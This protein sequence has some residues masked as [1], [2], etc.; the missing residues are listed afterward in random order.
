MGLLLSVDVSM[1]SKGIKVREMGS[2]CNFRGYRSLD[3][4]LLDII[5]IHTCKYPKARLLTAHIRE[6][7]TLNE[8]G[9]FLRDYEI[10]TIMRK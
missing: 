3:L 8:S 6:E 5:G 4:F 1:Q 9:S 10:L 2:S 7:K